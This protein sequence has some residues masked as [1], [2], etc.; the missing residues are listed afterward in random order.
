VWAG[1][2]LVAL[3][4]LLRGWVG[5]RG[6]L[7]QD[8]YVFEYRAA[9]MALDNPHYLL[10][11]WNGH[12]MPGGFLLVRL[13]TWLAPL[14][15][16]PAVTMDLVLQAV[17]GIAL[18]ALLR[19]LF[20]TRK[21]IL[22][23]MTLFLFSPVTLTG[24]VWWA[25]ALNQLPAMLA[26][27]VT[28]YLHVRYLR[29]GRTRT[30]L[31]ALGAFALGLAF[32]EKLLVFAPLVPLVTAMYFVA[33]SWWRR[34]V[35]TLT[36]HWRI[37]IAWLCL[38][39]P[40]AIYYETTVNS[41]VSRRTSPT[42][43]LDLLSTSWNGLRVGVVGGP[44]NWFSLNDSA[45]AIPVVSGMLSTISWVVMFAVVVGSAVVFRQA[46]RAWL[47]PGSYFLATVVLLTL[48]RNQ[49]GPVIGLAYRYFSEVAL[50]AAIALPL[51]L[52]PL[53]GTVAKG[54]VTVLQRRSWVKALLE[55]L[56]HP[57]GTALSLSDHSRLVMVRGV[58]IALV[59]ST[60]LSTVRYDE[61]WRANP[62]SR[63]VAAVRADLA[64]APRDLVLADT[65]VPGGM[66]EGLFNPYNSISH[67]LAP[68]P[69]PPHFL[70][71][72]DWTPDLRILD[73]GGHIRQVYV[74]GA[75]NQP[76]P[77][78]SCGWFASG[79]AGVDIPMAVPVFNFNWTMRIGYIASTDTRAVIT[80][81][82][83]IVH[84]QLQAGL[85]AIYVQLSGP[86]EFVRIDGLSDDASGCTADVRV[87]PPVAL[88]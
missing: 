71:A 66:M 4:A 37:W 22:V 18:L 3:Q 42:A 67:V 55:R 23:P 52:L 79:A 10:D 19:E 56:R 72:G 53:V 32:F 77:G 45:N 11:A 57:D 27:V 81:A 59:L 82:Q 83:Q 29:S 54:E 17:T 69:R 16:W 36:L 31:Y 34:L 7:A 47:L 25:A 73:D 46:L 50:L 88:P 78:S 24:F 9:S 48:G 85:H 51:A 62:G 21:A 1:L 80:A 63:Y 28:L 6:S 8:D 76:G 75:R 20:G 40:Y 26:I 61:H 49:L 38:L 13:A 70:K 84:V 39:T 15:L 30:G 87:G 12:L 33:G 43:F 41:T 58:I 14:Q 2:A 64:K 65:A 74:D 68:L 60:G 35:S 86:I 44:W 5:M